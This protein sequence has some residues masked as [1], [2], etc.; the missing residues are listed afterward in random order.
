MVL[1]FD[2]GIS[3]VARVLSGGDC[4]VVEM[5]FNAERVTDKD[6]VHGVSARGVAD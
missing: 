6:Q 1:G 5:S 2:V 3:W 4:R